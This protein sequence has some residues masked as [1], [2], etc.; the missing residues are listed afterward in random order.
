M[1]VDRFFAGLAGWGRLA[2]LTTLLGCPE[3]TP[4]DRRAKSAF[5]A[6]S[7]PDVLLVV[8][9][10]MRVDRLSTYGHSRP[11]SPQLDLIAAAG[12]VFDDVTAPSSWTWPK[13]QKLSSARWTPRTHR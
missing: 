2:L 3:P 6:D 7:R 10:T 11:T 8:L 1:A 9:D 5:D 4:A 13:C 12:V